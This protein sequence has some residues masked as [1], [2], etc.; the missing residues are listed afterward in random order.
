MAHEHQA[1]PHE[2]E[3]GHD[4]ERHNH[5]GGILARIRGL[6]SPHS[7]D[8]AVSVDSALETSRKG[9]RALFISFLALGL[10]A[11]LQAVV[12]LLS[13]SVALLGDTPHN[14]ADAL[15]AIP[16]AIAFTLGR[17]A[18]TR[19]FTYGYGRSEDIAGIIVVVFIAG[20]SALA[21][22]EAVRRLLHPQGLSY[23]WLVGVAGLIGFLGNELVARYRIKVGREIGSAALVADGL[24]AR[25]D[26][27]TSLGVPIGAIGVA[28]GFRPADPIVGLAI[29]LAI[30][31]VLR[32][33]GREVLRRLMD[34][35]DPGLVEQVRTELLATPG[36]LGLGDVRLRWIGH[37]LRAECEVVVAHDLSVVD[38][39]TI[40]EDAQHRLL[41]SIPRLS[42]ALVHADP[43]AHQGD[44]HH[45]VTA[46]HAGGYRANQR[47]TTHD[48]PT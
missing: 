29:T 11:I 7:H 38:A 21:G 41:H 34:A 8:A 9:N 28:F 32:D 40:T 17:R 30:L 25:T 18:A 44:D 37:A 23:L 2:P 31:V 22:Y 16:L 6:F 19:R 43:F 33:A 26:G 4:E 15:T 47:E 24:H 14:L 12:V 46:H 27:I 20:S 42:A 35:V 13:H 45:E 1:V 5:D 39:H 48:R 36:V 10:T 3:R